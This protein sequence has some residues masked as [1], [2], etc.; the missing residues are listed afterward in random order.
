MNH[1]PNKYFCRYGC[2]NNGRL[3]CS[4]CDKRPCPLACTKPC[5]RLRAY[6]DNEPQVV[7]H[8]A[9]LNSKPVLSHGVDPIWREAPGRVV[10]LAKGPGPRSALVETP[11]GLVV[12][13][14]LNLRWSKKC[15]G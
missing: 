3:C 1:A 13:P 7:I 10:A 4:L 11:H 12:V 8:Y 15:T 5:D 2:M 14:R 6:H 9:K